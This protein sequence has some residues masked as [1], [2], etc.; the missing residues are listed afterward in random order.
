[1][2]QLCPEL[3]NLEGRG[4]KLLLMALLGCAGVRVENP[5]FKSRAGGFVN[6]IVCSA[7]ARLKTSLSGF[8]KK[9]TG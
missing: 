1:M 2:S 8:A 7:G 3:N 9:V 4:N 5:G 6:G